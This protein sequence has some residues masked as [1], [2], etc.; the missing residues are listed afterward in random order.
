MNGISGSIKAPSRRI[1][2]VGAFSG[3]P[4]HQPRPSKVDYEFYFT[5]WVKRK[6]CTEESYG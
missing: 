3:Q 5:M 1:R 4:E 6:F 2:Y